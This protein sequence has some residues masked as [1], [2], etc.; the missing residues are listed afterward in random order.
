M[1]E[2]WRRAVIVPLY[3]GKGSRG[4]C[5]SYR[6]II[7]IS[8]AIKVYGRVLNEMRMEKIT[9]SAG[10]EQGFFRK[11]RGCVGQT[12]ALKMLVEK[13]LMRD[14]KLIAAFMDLKKAYD[15]VDRKGLWDV[16]RVYTY[17]V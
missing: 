16:L 17:V 13:Y 9:E 4:D 6:G 1:P 8:V 12:F 15:K 7:L 2:A 5:N 10:Y 14:R 3:K 11:D